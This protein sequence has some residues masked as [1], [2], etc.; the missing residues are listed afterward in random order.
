MVTFHVFRDLMVALWRL[1]RGVPIKEIGD[2][3]VS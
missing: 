2:R 1:G 3:K